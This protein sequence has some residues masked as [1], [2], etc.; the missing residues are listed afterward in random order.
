MEKQRGGEEAG[1]CGGGEAAQARPGARPRGWRCVR[2][3]GGGGSKGAGCPRGCGGAGAILGPGG[4]P[5]NR[6]GG[7]GSECGLFINVS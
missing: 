5:G 2:H 3:L 4:E 1:P 7:P 6:S